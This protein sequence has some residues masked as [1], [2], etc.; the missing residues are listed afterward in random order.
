MP[1]EHRP[2]PAQLI[3]GTD[4]K[5]IGRRRRPLWLQREAW[6]FTIALALTIAATIAVLWP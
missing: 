2:R 1:H 6:P 5:P 3:L 4:G